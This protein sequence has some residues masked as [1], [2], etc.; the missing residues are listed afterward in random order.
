[1]S[2]QL[3][4]C[5]FCD[6]GGFTRRGLRQHWCDASP[7]AK[8]TRKTVQLSQDQWQSMTMAQERDRNMIMA[9]RGGK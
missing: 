3:Y 7:A 1:M 2:E 9:K 4:Q 8:R 5:V 6:Q